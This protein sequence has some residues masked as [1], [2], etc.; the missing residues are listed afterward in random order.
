VNIVR[1]CGTIVAQFR[2]A[3]PPAR[4]RAILQLAFAVTGAILKAL[5]P[6]I[7]FPMAEHTRWHVPV[8]IEDVPDTGLHLDLIAT[9]EVRANLAAFAGL[10]DLSRLEAV[11]DLVRNGGGLRATGCVRATAGQ[12]CIITLEPVETEIDEAFDVRFAPAGTAEAGVSKNASESD[13]PPEAMIDGTADIGAV[14][15]EFLLLGINPYPRKPGAMFDRPAEDMT[16]EGPFA[17]L[18]KLRKQ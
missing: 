12:S 9:D 4:P 8:R 6:A 18:S 13:D 3:G 15:T 2:A 10:R 5:A 17:A 1:L 7:W 14:A 16:G 11:V